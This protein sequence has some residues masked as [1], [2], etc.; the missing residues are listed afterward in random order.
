VSLFNDYRDRVGAALR[1]LRTASVVLVS[2]PALEP[3]TLAEVRKHLGRDGDVGEI[4]P[5]A[6]TAALAG[7]GAGNVDNGAHRYGC[8]FVTADGET[9]LGTVTAAVTVADKTADGRVALSTIPLGGSA[10]TARKIYRTVA[11]GS[12]YLLLTT[13]GDNTTTTYADN[14]ADSGLGAQAPSVNSTAEPLLTRWIKAARQEL[15]GITGRALI[16][17]THDLVIDVAPDTSLVMFPK[18][19]L[20]SVSS[21][22]SYDA[23]DV[24]TVMAA[25]DYIV[26]AG[27]RPGRLTLKSTASWPTDLRDAKA[28]V[29]RFVCGYGATSVSIPEP[30]RQAMLLRIG[31]WAEHRED[32]LMAQFA[33]QFIELPRG[34]KALINAGLEA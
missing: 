1:M 6:P 20:Q 17:Q 29:F 33:G 22:T 5:G 13:I 11:G 25:S 8:T 28:I 23:D 26:D 19:P 12:T 31:T 16:T 24:A 34:Y 21:V 15:E 10:V 4:A 30:F 3:F 32:V 9:E 2:G 18:A 7:A 27:A 14:T